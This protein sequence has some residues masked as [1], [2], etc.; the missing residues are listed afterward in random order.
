M[1]AA[2]SWMLSSLDAASARSAYQG[3]LQPLNQN[4]EPNGRLSAFSPFV[5]CAR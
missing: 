4:V 1:R 5:M 2:C 3:A